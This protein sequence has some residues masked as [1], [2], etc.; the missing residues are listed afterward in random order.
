LDAKDLKVFEA[1]ARCEGM[2]RAAIELNTVQSNVTAR[3]RLLETEL[4]V[5]LFERRP[6]GMKLTPAGAR[7]LP[8]A[9]EVR[10]AIANAKR[11]VTDVGTPSGPL[12]VGSRKSTS[13]LHLTEV[14]ISYATAFPDVEIKVRT[15]TSPLLTG[16]V[17]ERKIEGAFVCGPVEHHDLVKEVIFDDELVILTAPEITDLKSLSLENTKMIVLGQGSL[18]QKQLE[19]I[20]VRQGFTTKRVMELGTVTNIVG[21]VS[22]GVGVSLLPKGIANSISNKGAVH[23]HKVTDEDCR[24]QTL[25]IRRRDGFVSSALSAFL[26]AARVYAQSLATD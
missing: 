5:A 13:A 21:C 10:A 16:L 1:V 6:S 17:L 24:V 3:I 14:L 22:A 26:N 19:E 20:L 2:N 25:F 4:G 18:Y 7:L 23:I 8:Y 11:A 9:F 12:L 15:E